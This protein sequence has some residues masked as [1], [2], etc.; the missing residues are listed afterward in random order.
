MGIRFYCPNG[1]KM[2]VKS[3]LAGCKGICPVCGAKMDIPLESTRPSSRHPEQQPQPGATGSESPQAETSKPTAV[4]NQPV[5][6]VEFAEASPELVAMTLDEAQRGSSAAT[7]AAGPPVDPLAT[8]GNVVW[9]VRPPTGGQFGPATTDIMR[10]W[11]AEGRLSTDTLVWREGW[12]EWQEAGRLFP[13]LSLGPIVPDLEDVL[14]DPA[15]ASVAEPVHPHAPRG[16]I[17][18][19]KTQLIALG[20]LIGV[21]LVLLTIFLVVWLR[22]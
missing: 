18:P 1:H 13:Q 21:V 17:P 11:L 14:A 2:N 9:Y 3:F 20:S 4:P 8:D 10:G 19:K 5:P 16:H 6:T 12:R 22:Q 7:F 15:A